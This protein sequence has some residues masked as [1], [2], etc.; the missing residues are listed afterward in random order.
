MEKDNALRLDEVLDKYFELLT[1]I[2]GSCDD[3]D[4][5][6]KDR[7]KLLVQAEAEIRA[8]F[9]PMGSEE[10]EKRIF[11][12]VHSGY[13]RNFNSDDIEDEEE[14][15]RRLASALSAIEELY[16]PEAE[17]KKR[18]VEY[19]QECCT[20]KSELELENRKLKETISKLNGEK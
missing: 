16:K 1:T 6:E 14:T 18:L 11:D 2:Q 7:A 17:D 8:L 13:L 9:K 19:A 15:A 4:I 3:V 10:I 5:I 12:L 20:K